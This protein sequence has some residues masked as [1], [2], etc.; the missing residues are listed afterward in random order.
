MKKLLTILSITFCIAVI[1]PS[2]SSA[3]EGFEDIVLNSDLDQTAPNNGDDN[4][5]DPTPGG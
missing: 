2:C 1:A 4:D 5:P 3:D